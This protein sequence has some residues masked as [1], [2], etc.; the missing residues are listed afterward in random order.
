MSN[1]TTTTD[2]HSTVVFREFPEAEASHHAPACDRGEMLVREK[3]TVSS[4]IAQWKRTL[5]EDTARIP[6]VTSS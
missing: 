3:K 5:M 1:F 4:L 6:T 2:A